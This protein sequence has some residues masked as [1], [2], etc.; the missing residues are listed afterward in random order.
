MWWER[1]K[2]LILK[3]IMLKMTPCGAD[4]GCNISKSLFPLQGWPRKW[5][6]I[7][8]ANRD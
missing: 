4:V 1:M 2:A 5:T 3:E 7:L 8:L 6:W